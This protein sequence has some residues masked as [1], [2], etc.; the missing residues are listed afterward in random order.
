MSSTLM[1]LATTRWVLGHGGRNIGWLAAAAQSAASSS[2]RPYCYASPPFAGLDEA[3]RLPRLAVRG[4]RA[5][6]GC[7]S[8]TEFQQSV[9]GR[10][11]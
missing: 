5:V 9:A 1:A 2:C 3:L 10:V 7:C 4:Q 6:Q 8:M 11:A